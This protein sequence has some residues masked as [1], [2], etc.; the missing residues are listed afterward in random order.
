MSKEKAA[1]L[2][3]R[4]L[5]GVFGSLDGADDER[6]RVVRQLLDDVQLVRYAPQ[7]GDYSERL[8]ELAARAS[9]VVRKW[10]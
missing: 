4:T 9:D 2:I 3:E 5:H 8:R 10:A 1:G 7:L 6:G